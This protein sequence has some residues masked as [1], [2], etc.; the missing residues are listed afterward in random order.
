MAAASVLQLIVSFRQT[1]I[2]EQQL[3]MT[4]KQGAEKVA[5]PVSEPPPKADPS[6]DR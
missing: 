3:R 6:I 2:A 4:P 5:K 1:K